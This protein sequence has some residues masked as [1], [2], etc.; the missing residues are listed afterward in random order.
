M[1]LYMFKNIL[2]M[3]NISNVFFIS[4]KHY[5]VSLFIAQ[6]S[7]LKIFKIKQSVFNK[8]I[9]YILKKENCVMLL[10]IHIMATK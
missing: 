6:F 2:K 4:K 5:F 9:V 3:P 10:Y 1:I 7:P 8:I